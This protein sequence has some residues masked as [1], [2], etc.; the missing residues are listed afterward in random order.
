MRVDLLKAR[1]QPPAP[2]GGQKYMRGLAICPL[3]HC[4][5]RLGQTRGQWHPPHGEPQRQTHQNDRRHGYYHCT[6]HHTLRAESVGDSLR[7]TDRIITARNTDLWMKNQ[8]IIASHL[9]VI[10]SSRY[11]ARAQIS[12]SYMPSASIL[13]A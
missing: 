2:I 12:G 10:S 1:R 13:G 11:S 4:R 5:I 3:D 8:S 9:C 7:V 6:F